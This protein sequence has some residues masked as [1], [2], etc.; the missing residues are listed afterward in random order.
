MSYIALARKWRP[1]TFNQLIGQESVTKALVSSLKQQRLHHAYLFTGTHGV[2]K[3]T[4][5]RILAKAL[6]CEQ[7]IT[8]EPCLECDFCTAI[9]QN[10]LIDLIEVDGA[11]RTRVED[12]RELLENIHYSPTQARFKIYIIDEVHM[13]SQHSFNALLKTLEEPPAHVK[14]MLATTDSQK[15]P[16]TILSRCLQFNLKQVDS[17]LIAAHLAKILDEETM[18]YEPAALTLLAN[19]SRGSVRDAL[20][21][22]DQIIPSCDARLEVSTVNSLMGYTQ[23]DVALQLLHCLATNNAPELLRVSQ[24]IATEGGHFQYVLDTM[25][26]YLHQ[27]VLNHTLK[28]AQDDLISPNQAIIE[29]CSDISVEDAQLFYQIG[30]RGREEMPLAPTLA[31]GFEMTLLRMYTFKPAEH[32][33]NPLLAH[34]EKKRS[35]EIPVVDSTKKLPTSDGLSAGSSSLLIPRDVKSQELQKSPKKP[36]LANPVTEK[37]KPNIQSLAAIDTSTLN[38][39]RPTACVPLNSEQPLLPWG[40][41]LS[42]LS[43]QGLALH[44]A[45][46]AELVSQTASLIEL[47]IAKEH[48]SAYTPAVIERISNALSKYYQTNIRISLINDGVVSASP[49]QEKKNKAIKNQQEAE[50]ALQEDPFL[51]ELQETFSAELVKDSVVPT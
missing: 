10:R 39:E 25:L 40:E 4:L 32:L 38:N 31:I 41:I 34:Q 35:T 29:L 17:T 9:E 27:I 21:L 49:A 33:P 12:T 3:T 44:A 18:A 42:K 50:L 16:L 36:S 5:T 47:R 43:L 6:C 7:G 13:L 22:L 24:L 1:R 15:L 30:L 26:G 2:G 37:T 11:S 51:H 28:L 20:S 45:E 14:F 19:A 23:Q 8:P 46:Q 48:R